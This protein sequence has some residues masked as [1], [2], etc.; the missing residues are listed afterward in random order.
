[1]KWKWITLLVVALILIVPYKIESKREPLTF[2]SSTLGDR[3]RIQGI[4]Y[5]YSSHHRFDERTQLYQI[6]R[7]FQ[8]PVVSYDFITV[9][10]YYNNYFSPHY[11]ILVIDNL[12]VTIGEHEDSDHRILI[13][14]SW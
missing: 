6:H 3:L 4:G 13:N 1:M 10:F 8:I 7:G 12:H 5:K 14:W 9:G 11:R 2:S